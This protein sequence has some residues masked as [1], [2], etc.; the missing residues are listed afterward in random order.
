VGI[1]RL[2]HVEVRQ[3]DLELGTAYYT[4]VLGL[5]R[6]AQTGDRVFLKCW[7]EHEHHSV[8]L[9]EAP[10]HGIEHFG[11]KCTEAGDLDELGGR[12]AAYGCTVD[13]YE[14]GELGPGHGAA[15]RFDT[16]TGHRVELVY[17]MTRVGNSLPL[18]NPPVRPL[19]LVGIAPPRLDHVFITCEDVE[20][21]LRFYREVLGFRLTE[22]I[23]GDDGVRI[24]VFLERSHTPHDIA[25]ITGPQGGLHHIA[26]WLDDWNG[27]RDAA[28]L[29]AYNGIP[30]EVNPTRH[31]ATRGY[32]TYFFDPAGNRNEV[33][34][35]GYWVDPE[36]EP[37][38]WTEAEMG[39]AIFYYDG[40]VDPRFFTVH[41]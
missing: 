40:V 39:R 5:Q 9:R 8:I 28:D 3:P 32:T 4:E 10:T 18:T 19:D 16:P 26:F 21:A 35:G 29:L 20:E 27:V 13:K 37:V 7:D 34:T 24:A 1:L 17:G 33:F 23:V 15:V 22:Q 41:S 36:C 30:I 12:A 14:P 31:G 38:T 11:F 25:M 6:T 2:S